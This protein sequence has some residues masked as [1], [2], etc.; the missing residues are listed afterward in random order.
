M[1]SAKTE[2]DHQLAAYTAGCDVFSVTLTRGYNE[3]LFRE[4][5]KGLY[6]QLAVKPTA[7]LF[8]D[9]HV[10]EEGFL[11]LI[12]NM[13]TSGMVPA[14]YEESEKDGIVSGIRDEAVKIANAPDTKEGVWAYYVG[15]CRDNLHVILAMSPVGETL[16]CTSVRYVDRTAIS[17]FVRRHWSAVGR[18]L[19]RAPPSPSGRRQ[20][21][22]AY[23]EL[24]DED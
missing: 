11:E 23:T 22:R 6:Q 19:G 7:F 21:V 2:A 16:P 3:A 13:L 24:P 1:N 4:D 14:L 10:A 18:R 12:N 20:L 8:T 5:L 17:F 15:K 9:A